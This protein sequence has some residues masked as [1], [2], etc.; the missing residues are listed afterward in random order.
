MD[1]SQV[2]GPEAIQDAQYG[3]PYHFLPRLEHGR[4]RFHEVLGWGHEYLSYLTRI[5][6]VLAQR[7]WT[8]LLDVG[9]GDGR[10]V[11]HLGQRFE[12]RRLTGLD[13]SQRAITLARAMVPEADFLAA[14]V[15]KA[16]LFEDRFDCAT[17]IETI[18]HIEPSFLPQFV[19][20]IRQHL[21]PG[22]T[23]VVTVP[24][25]NVPVTDKHYQHFTP[26]L[27]TK[28]LAG[29]FEVERIEYLNG[30]S[31]VADAVRMLITNRLYTVT[32]PA[33]LTA[34]YNFYVSRYL[35]S[36]SRRGGRILACC[37]AR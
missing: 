23:L 2:G 3:F 1:K 30:V 7:Q 14:D 25:T 13:Y 34:F 9:C 15:T 10:L 37:T 29:P 5:A 26:E 27:L 18:E 19:S 21:K 24:S 22:A 16:G 20:G 6:D 12:G 33:A 11:S 28:T 36:D 17:C 32:N 4:F 31:R 8:S 35:K